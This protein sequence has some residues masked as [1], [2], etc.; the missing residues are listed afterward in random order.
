ML[1]SAKNLVKFVSTFN[2]S[3]DAVIRLG[4]NGRYQV[5][6]FLELNKGNANDI[7]FEIM[8]LPTI[9]TTVR[10]SDDRR[11]I[12]LVGE[13]DGYKV[14]LTF[15]K[16]NPVTIK[17]SDLVDIKRG[18]KIE[19]P[20]FHSLFDE[21][22]DKE[23]RHYLTPSEWEIFATEFKKS[24]TKAQQKSMIKETSL[25]SLIVGSLTWRETPQGEEFWR[26]IALRTSNV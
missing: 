3:D 19:S 21:V 6:A 12:D 5:E 14:E 10:S 16:M 9:E 2:P 7:Y 18:E 23:Y 13:V 17:E 26:E 22:K 15:L 24:N 11:Y 1:Q 25:F 20:Y 4:I 8:C